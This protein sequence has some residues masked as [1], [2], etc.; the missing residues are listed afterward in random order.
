MGNLKTA[1]LKR[2]DLLKYLL[3]TIAS[4]IFPIRKVRASDWSY[5]RETGSSF[6]GKLAP[7]FASCAVGEAQSPIDINSSMA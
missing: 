1:S 4:S 3:V 5:R 2:R 7:E 6:W